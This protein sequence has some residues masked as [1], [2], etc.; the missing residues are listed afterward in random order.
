MSSL[1]E[2]RKRSKKTKRLGPTPIIQPEEYEG[3]DVETK[4]AVAWGFGPNTIF[5]GLSR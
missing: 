3:F 1:T 4:V 2:T 5:S